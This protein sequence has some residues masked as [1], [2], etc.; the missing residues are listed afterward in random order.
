M[1]ESILI[2]ATKIADQGRSKRERKKE[3]GE[4]KKACCRGTLVMGHIIKAEAQLY[5]KEFSVNFRTTVQIWIFS[6]LL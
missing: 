3:K 5:L 1:K 4:R 6:Q 2:G